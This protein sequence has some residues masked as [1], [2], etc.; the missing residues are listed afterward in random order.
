MKVV[1]RFTIQCEF[2]QTAGEIISESLGGLFTV[3]VATGER[4]VASLLPR[5]NTTTMAH[6]MDGTEEAGTEV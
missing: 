6:A 3:T 1:Q 2:E 4:K 5:K